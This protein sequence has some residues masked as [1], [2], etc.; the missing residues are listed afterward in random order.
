MKA[1]QCQ[2]PKSL[3]HKSGNTKQTLG[4]FQN[5]EQQRR[6]Y[7]PPIFPPS[8]TRF[9][10]IVPWNRASLWLVRPWLRGTPASAAARAP[11][12]RPSW[13][14][15][16]DG[17]VAAAAYRCGVPEDGLGPWTGTGRGVNGPF[18]YVAGPSTEKSRKSD[19]SMWPTDKS[20]WAESVAECRFSLISMWH[21]TYRVLTGASYV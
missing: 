10:Q 2:Q 4:H 6:G 9:L 20:Y 19:H 21:W 5:F 14:S 15:R 18:R 11:L 1:K 17:R 16:C 3:W 12:R 8:K 13:W 7:A